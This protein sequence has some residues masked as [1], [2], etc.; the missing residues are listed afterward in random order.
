MKQINILTYGGFNTE[1]LITEEVGE[2]F[3]NSNNK[4]PVNLITFDSDEWYQKWLLRYL[5][6]DKDAV[7]DEKFGKEFRLI[8]TNMIQNPEDYQDVEDILEGLGIPQ[9]N[10]I[11][12]GSKTIYEKGTV[13]V[14]GLKTK[15]W[16]RWI[17]VKK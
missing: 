5:D 8:Y 2:F 13:D 12:D 15:F 10:L 9:E 6:E 7:P 1:V 14:V 4:D 16:V 17:V 3:E 11:F